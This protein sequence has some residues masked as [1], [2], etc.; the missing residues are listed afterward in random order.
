MVATSEICLRKR[1]EKFARRF[2]IH[3]CRHQNV[4]RRPKMDL[5]SL[6]FDFHA[7]FSGDN[8]TGK[9]ALVSRGVLA[10]GIVVL[11]NLSRKTKVSNPIIVANPIDVIKLTN[12]HRSVNKQPRDAMGLKAPIVDVDCTVSV[13]C[14]EIGALADPIGACVRQFFHEDAGLWIVVQSSFGFSEGEVFHPAILL[15]Q[16]IPRKRLLR[17]AP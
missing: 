5:P 11:L 10:H 7:P 8:R 13:R 4:R 6:K 9:H 1:T 15:I 3:P 12:R 14:L 16:I 17:R 2:V